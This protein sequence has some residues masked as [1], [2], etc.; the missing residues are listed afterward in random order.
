MSPSPTVCSLAHHYHYQDTPL[1]ASLTQANAG[2]ICRHCCSANDVCGTDDGAGPW[3]GEGSQL[4]YSYAKID[5]DATQVCVSFAS[6]ILMTYPFHTQRTLDVPPHAPQCPPPKSVKHHTV[7]F[8][9]AQCIIN[10]AT[11]KSHCMSLPIGYDINDDS[12]P[13]VAR[14]KRRVFDLDR[15]VHHISPL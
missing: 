7:T 11:G 10:P 15:R 5:P 12:D 3:C 9:P 6:D 4:E 13:T 14:M 2:A 8:Q 1:I